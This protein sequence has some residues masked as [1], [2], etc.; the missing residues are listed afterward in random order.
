MPINYMC[1]MLHHCVSKF[2]FNL[3]YI[4][5]KHLKVVEKRS[6]RHIY[7]Y[8]I[9]HRFSGMCAVVFDNAKVESIGMNLC[10]P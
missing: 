2:N 10:L 9:T 7:T 8:A 4:G 3:I 6:I 1:G 5:S